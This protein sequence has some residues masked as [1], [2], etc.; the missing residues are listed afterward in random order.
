MLDRLVT[1]FEQLVVTLGFAA[2]TLLLF[3][4]VVARYAFDTGFPWV[5]E[6]VQYLFAWVVLIGAAHGVKAGVHLGIDILTRKFPLAVQRWLALLALAV[7]LAFTIPVL[8]LSVE[9]TFKVWQWGDLT[10][11]LQIPQWIPYLAIPV[12]LT[13]MTYRFFQVGLKIWRGE[14]FTVGQTEHEQMAAG[15]IIE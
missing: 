5:L 1:L 9:Y 3:A 13:L 4:N 8:I 12:G 6:T 14:R 10:L 2:G 15:E 11:D 7:C